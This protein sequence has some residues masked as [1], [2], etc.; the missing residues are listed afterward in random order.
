[1]G[2]SRITND[3]KINDDADLFAFRE[4][5]PIGLEFITVH[6]SFNNSLRLVMLSELLDLVTIND[7]CSFIFTPLDSYLFL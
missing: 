6:P 7:R 4:A 5:P 3:A 2:F 1:M